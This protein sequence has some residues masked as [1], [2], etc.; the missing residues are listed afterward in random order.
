MSS[1]MIV[2]D[3][4]APCVQFIRAGLE[5]LQSNVLLSKSLEPLVGAFLRH[6]HAT[7]A[8]RQ[9]VV[10]ITHELYEVGRVAS[11]CSGC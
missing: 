4:D 7:P 9:L 6:S 8:F 1:S 5:A 2:N 11:V 10:H 3:P